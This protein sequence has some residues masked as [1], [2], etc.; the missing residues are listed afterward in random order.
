[1]RYRYKLTYRRSKIEEYVLH[2]RSETLDEDGVEKKVKEL[3]EQHGSEIADL[4]GQEYSGLT[5]TN[6]RF[7]RDSLS[8]VKLMNVEE[9]DFVE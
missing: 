9:V 5:I 7:E 6:G 4:H 2:I 8:E 1:M 3:W